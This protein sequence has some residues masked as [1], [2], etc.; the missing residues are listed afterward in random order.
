MEIMMTLEKAIKTALEYENKVRDTYV[1]FAGKVTDPEGKRVFEVLGRE[2][3]EH[4][5]YLESRLTEWQKSGHLSETKLDSVVPSK[6]TIAAGV[7]KLDRHMDKRDFGTERD[8]LR[9]ALALEQETSKFY[10]RMV[11]E[12][13]EDGKLFARFLEIEEGHQVIVQAEI[14]YLEK[15]GYFFDF[16]EFTMEH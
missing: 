15:N 14:D 16:Q 3:Q 5:D 6:D 2:E 4:I 7:E 11:D 10:A 9:K 13:G 1:E 8:M 12:M